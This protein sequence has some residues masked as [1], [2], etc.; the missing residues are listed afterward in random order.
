MLNYP[1]FGIGTLL[2][3]ADEGAAIQ[4]LG[5]MFPEQQIALF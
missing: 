4:I 1:Q 3:F 2:E 5:F